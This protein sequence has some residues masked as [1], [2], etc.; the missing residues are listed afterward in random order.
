MVKNEKI[1]REAYLIF[2]NKTDA[3]EF[4][5]LKQNNRVKTLFL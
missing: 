4:T 5:F 2:K 1:N 3:K